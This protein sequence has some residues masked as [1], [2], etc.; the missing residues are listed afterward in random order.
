MTLEGTITQI[1]PLEEGASAKGSWKKQSFIVNTGGEYSS[2]VCFTIWGAK[3]EEIHLSLNA[4][5]EVHFNLLSREYNNKWYTEAKAWK[6]VQKVA[7]D[8]Q[9]DSNAASFRISEDKGHLPF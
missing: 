5:V 6:L 3:I 4:D 7:V 8:L 2:N 9:A 1:L